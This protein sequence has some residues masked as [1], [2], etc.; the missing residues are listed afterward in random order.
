MSI[1]QSANTHGGHQLRR[2]VLLGSAVAILNSFENMT[3]SGRP[4]TEKDWNPVTLEDAL[5]Q[6]SPVLA[7]NYAKKAAEQAAWDFV[8]YHSCHFDMCVIN[9]DIIIGPLIQPVKGKG[10]VNETNVFA[11]YS[12]INGMHK[13]VDDAQFPFYHFVDVRDVARAHVIA[14]TEREAAGK[15]IL[16]VSGLIT[17]RLVGGIIGRRFPELTGRLPVGWD[18]EVGD[19][20]PEGV[21]PTGWDGSASAEVLSKGGEEWRYRRLEESV[22]DTVNSLLEWEKK[23]EGK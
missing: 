21:K 15:R 19:G 4:Y 14:M 6:N 20:L 13:S 11:V 23:W 5:S 8:G 3:T 1:L 16:Q 7:Y 9:P 17:P 10:N 12:F 22:V 2:F 18:G